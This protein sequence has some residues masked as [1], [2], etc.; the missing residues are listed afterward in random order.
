MLRILHGLNLEDAREEL[1]RAGFD[2][3][4]VLPESL[5]QQTV[6]KLQLPGNDADALLYSLRDCRGFSIY[7]SDIG[8]VSTILLV[9]DLAGLCLERSVQNAASPLNKI[10]DE[11]DRLRSNWRQNSWEFTIAADNWSIEAPQVMGILNVTPDSF[12]DGGQFSG[13]DSAI[14]HGLDMI[15]AGAD[16]IDIGAESTRPGA[17]A[18][19]PDEEWRRLSPVLQALRR[20]ADVKISVDTCKA[21]VARKALENGAD[22]INDISGLSADP[23]IATLAARYKVP[24]VLMHMKGTPETMQKNPQY[25]DL[26]AEILEFLSRQC[27]FAR[28]KGVA[29]LIVD[30]GIGFGKKPRDNY[31]ILRRL[32]ELTQL[33][34]P[35]LLGTSRKS[36]IGWLDDSPVDRR[37]GGSLA[38]VLH[39]YRQGA[40]IFR[41]HDV[42][43]TRQALAVQL[44]MEQ[45]KTGVII[46][47]EK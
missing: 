1:R 32:R 10:I 41:V 36:F 18:V 11:I 46:N 29:D 17:D 21:E 33:G 5:T 38:S 42:A 44:A 7:R 37:I 22:M 28:E 8:V 27:R 20:E 31:E 23:E 14:A 16:I 9:G 15:A 43:E 39:G 40:K 4:G 26:M 19:P 2:D 3:G 30:P 47:N 13:S 6:L 35:L 34:V 24:L 12:S 45:M 25:S